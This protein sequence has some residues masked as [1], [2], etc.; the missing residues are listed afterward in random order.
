MDHWRRSPGD[1]EAAWS[2]LTNAVSPDIA[3]LQESVPPSTLP[4]SGVVYREIGR[5][6]PWGSAVVALNPEIELDEIWTVRTRYSPQTF[7][8]AGTYPGA[9]AVARATL[10]KEPPI[11][12][13]SVYGL[14]D[15]YSQ[16][17]LFRVIADLIPLF[18]SEDGERVILAGDLNVGTDAAR[19]P[20]IVRY[21][22]I[23]RAFESLGLANLY[24]VVADRPAPPEN[25]RCGAVDC[26][27]L[28][29][30]EGGGQFDY[31]F[32]T[33]PLAAAARRIVR[34][35]D[36]ETRLLSDHWPIAAEFDLANVAGTLDVDGP[37]GPEAAEVQALAVA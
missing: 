28:T 2:R 15:V 17:T 12:L 37:G 34:F 24:E 36:P 6:R 32:A 31:L 1:R 13:V 14:I 11:T 5:T 23:L 18:D 7:A 25:C 4:R 9:V 35:D 27:H 16:T 33:A 8:V 10:P 30:R 26:R 3:L 21:E 29:T 20:E 22:A 19:G